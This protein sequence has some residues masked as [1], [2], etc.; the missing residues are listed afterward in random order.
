M[1]YRRALTFGGTFFFTVNLFDCSSEL[2]I[3]EVNLLRQA[4][5][6][7]QE[8]HQFKTLAMVVMP[9]HL[10]TIWQLPENDRDYAMRWNLIKRTFSRT[11]P[12]LDE[13]IGSS[14]HSKQERG[15]W[16][17][18]YWEHQIRDELDLARHVDYIHFNPVK[19]GY[20]SR[21]A[22]WQY[23][24]IHRA[25]KRGEIPEDWGGSGADDGLFGE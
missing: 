13:V 21:A 20:V 24:S 14:R 3:R 2:L 7:T 23:S 17:R 16:Q 1:Y 22:D 8:R 4:F 19:H 10:H 15:I 12:K 6:Y 11:L 5:R 9:D 25:I 18:R